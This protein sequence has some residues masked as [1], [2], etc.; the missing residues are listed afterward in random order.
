MLAEVDSI[1]QQMVDAM[2]LVVQAQSVAQFASMT[3]L[4]YETKMGE[5]QHSVN[6]LQ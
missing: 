6:Q 4:A 3:V 1:R 5:I 2:Q